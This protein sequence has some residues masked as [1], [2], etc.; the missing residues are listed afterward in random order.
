MY[1]RIISFLF[2]FFFLSLFLG[3]SYMIFIYTPAN[4]E[5]KDLTKTFIKNNKD[6]LRHIYS[7][8]SYRNPYYDYP[9]SIDVIV[10]TSFFKDLKNFQLTSKECIF[11]TLRQEC[12]LIYWWDELLITFH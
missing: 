1:N 12:P 10:K 7:I 5:D 11:T 3:I 8:E 2:K 6:K 4:Y 9:P